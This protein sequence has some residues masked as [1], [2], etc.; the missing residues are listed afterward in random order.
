M[1]RN[2]RILKTSRIN[3][4]EL[5]KELKKSKSI[6]LFDLRTGSAGKGFEVSYKHKRYRSRKDMKE[7]KGGR[8]YQA[9]TIIK[10]YNYMLV[11]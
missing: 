1:K 5:Y 4:S 8:G 11:S 6:T 9:Q 10:I 7:K 3:C 2:S